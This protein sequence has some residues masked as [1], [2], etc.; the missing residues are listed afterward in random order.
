MTKSHTQ[1]LLNFLVPCDA[2]SWGNLLTAPGLSPISQATSWHTFHSFI[3]TVTIYRRRVKTNGAFKRVPSI[4]TL[5]TICGF[6]LQLRP[7]YGVWGQ[8]ISVF[9]Y[10]EDTGI[11]SQLNLRQSLYFAPILPR[12]ALIFQ[13]IREGNLRM[14]RSMF[15]CRKATPSDTMPDGVTLLHV[16]SHAHAKRTLLTLQLA[17]RQSNLELVEHLLNSGADIHASDDDGRSVR[18]HRYR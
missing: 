8:C 14:V 5:G 6:R 9:L 18:I 15:Q 16:S 3:G 17:C 1:Q 2:E 12:K 4:T 11:S 10:R 13:Y 7:S